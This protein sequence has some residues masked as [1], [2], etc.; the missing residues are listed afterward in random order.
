MARVREEESL[1]EG[2]KSRPPVHDDLAQREF[3]AVAPNE[4]WLSD[5]TEHWA[6]EGKLYL[7]AVK[8]VLSNRIVGYSKDAQ[9]TSTLVVTALNNAVLRRG[10]ISGCALHTDRGAQFRSRKLQRAL[11][12]HDMTRSLGGV[13]AAGDNAAKESLLSL[14]Q[15]AQIMDHPDTNCG[16]DREVDRTHLPSTSSTVPPGALDAHRVRDRHE[17]TGHT[18]CLTKLSPICATDPAPEPAVLTGN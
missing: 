5:I 18:R 6:S 4:L 3:V 16:R 8:D 15:K 17:Q 1:R 14:P 9:M 2:R 13:G 12:R 11:T 7:C 10:D